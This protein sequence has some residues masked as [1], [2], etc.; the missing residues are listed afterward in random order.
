MGVTRPAA[1]A[2]ATWLS[3]L[4]AAITKTNAP[5]ATPLAMAVSVKTWRSRMRTGSSK[6]TAGN[7]PTT[8]P[9]GAGFWSR[10]AGK[11]P[12]QIGSSSVDFTQPPL[13]SAAM[14]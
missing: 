3:T 12:P 8:N 10:L 1:M 13:P 6:P 14:T 5:V 2:L 9:Q 11:A 7:Y 4:P